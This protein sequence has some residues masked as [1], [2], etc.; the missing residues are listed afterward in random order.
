MAQKNEGFGPIG[1]T[2]MAVVA[3]ATVFGI[4]FPNN[5]SSTSP[6]SSSTTYSSMTDEERYGHAYTR[7]R[8][9]QEGFSSKEANA[10]ADAVINFHRKNG[11]L[12]GN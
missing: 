10:A 3:I 11:K 5:N 12:G 1:G 6:P 8:M 7:E 2:I 4:L 9:R